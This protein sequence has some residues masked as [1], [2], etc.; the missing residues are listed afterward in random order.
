MGETFVFKQIAQM[1]FVS[2]I[3]CT[4]VKHL[5]AS[6]PLLKVAWRKLKL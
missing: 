6:K 3:M 5:F 1:Q 4:L 2:E